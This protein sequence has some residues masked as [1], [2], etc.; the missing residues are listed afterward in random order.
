MNLR[1]HAVQQN[2]QAECEDEQMVDGPSS[3]TVDEALLS[4][5][6]GYFQ[7][8]VLAYAGM[9]WISEA[10]E[11]ML[12]SFV[13]PAVQ[14][15][16]KLSS[17]D[18][19]MISS[20][21][22]AGMLIGASSC[23]IVSDAYGRKKGFLFTA[24]ATS[25][26]GLLSAF[27]PNYISLI[28]L[29]FVVGIGLGGG[30]VV[31]SWFL[32]F[33]PA[34]NRG[35]WM[36]VFSGFWTVGTILE[37]LLA[38]AVMPTLG[39]RWLLGLS[40][41]PSFLMLLFYGVTPESPR[42]LCMKGF[43]SDAMHILEQ[44]AKVNSVALPSGVLISDCNVELEE[45]PDP[46]EGI[47]L[48]T[49]PDPSEGTHLVTVSNQNITTDKETQVGAIGILFRLLSPKF[50]KSTLLLWMVF[51]GNAFSYYGVVL[52]TSA[53]SNRNTDCTSKLY[54]DHSGVLYKDVFITSL[55]EIPG[56]ILSAAIVDRVGRKMSMATMLFI[57]CI[58]LV[59]LLFHQ[60]EVLTTA[61]LFGAR[62]CISGS[63]TIVYIYAPEVYPT[64]VRSSGVGIASAV[65]RVGGILCPLV[66]VSLIKRC[67]QTTAVI[68]FELVVFSSGMAVCFFPFETS[69]RELSDSI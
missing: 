21:V 49:V 20:V 7:A 5:G 69:G 31:A 61:L 50:I 39:W 27:S 11:V 24:I 45:S 68:L 44:M 65:G 42:Y 26:A 29:R 15:E 1:A 9:G 59:P 38:W 67:H 47:R 60:K 58:F 40:S 30:P 18:E 41:L 6:F 28:I 53:L 37:A 16:W 14:I 63:F 2:I 55:A 23:G 43:K 48:I 22:F 17:H 57:S 33:I 54:S 36:V 25:V 62:M 34:P 66:A 13:G 46:S 8:L 4:M 35:T 56:L 10:M 64:S 51:F 52:L 32:E 3:Y 12:L 19:S